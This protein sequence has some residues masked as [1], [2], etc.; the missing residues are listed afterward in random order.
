MSS[1]KDSLPEAP[2]GT[3]NPFQNLFSGE[4]GISN[5]HDPITRCSIDAGPGSCIAYD[6]A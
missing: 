4:P 5:L 2:K 1:A 3:S 6:L